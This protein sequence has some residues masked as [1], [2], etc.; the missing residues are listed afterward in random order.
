MD[1]FLAAFH[2]LARR[3]QYEARPSIWETVATGLRNLST[4]VALPVAA[5]AIVSLVLL[6]RISPTVSRSEYSREVHTARLTAMRGEEAPVEVKGGGVLE[7]QL[8]ARGLPTS[9]VD[10]EIANRM[11][12][13]SWQGK[14]TANS[15]LVSIQLKDSLKPGLYWVRLYG[16]DRELLRE[17]GLNVR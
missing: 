11:G 13:I 2:Q 12:S 16:D 10:A 1:D 5:L 7:L 3:P 14:G 15:G 8:D 9:A 6:V 17:Y 4:P